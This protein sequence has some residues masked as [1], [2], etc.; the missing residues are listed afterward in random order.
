MNS[1]RNLVLYFDAVKAWGKK[2]SKPSYVTRPIKMMEGKGEASM[3]IG[4]IGVGSHKEDSTPADKLRCLLTLFS[5]SPLEIWIELPSCPTWLSQ[6]AFSTSSLHGVT[7]NPDVDLENATHP[8]NIPSSQRC[9]TCHILPW[10]NQT[11]L[12]FIKN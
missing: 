11:S 1:S 9:L 8:I 4:Q 2:G 7:M 10:Y 6:V 3:G 12:P 5:V